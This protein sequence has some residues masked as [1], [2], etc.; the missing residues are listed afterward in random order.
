MDVLPQLCKELGIE[1]QAPEHILY[2]LYEKWNES[3]EMKGPHRD[4]LLDMRSKRGLWIGNLAEKI[5][6][7]EPLTEEETENLLRLFS[8]WHWSGEEVVR[9]KETEIATALCNRVGTYCLKAGSRPGGSTVWDVH[10]GPSFEEVMKVCSA[11]ALEESCPRALRF[12]ASLPGAPPCMMDLTVMEVRMGYRKGVIEI[13]CRCD[14]PELFQKVLYDPRSRR[15]Y[16][17]MK[18]KK[19]VGRAGRPHKGLS[20]ESFLVSRLEASSPEK[21]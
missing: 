2:A 1:Y 12:T 21:N 16:V 17:L 19:P 5:S 15:G 20:L 13:H 3:V 4:A 18:K 14:A 8:V 7:I 10:A 6:G 11:L 9:G